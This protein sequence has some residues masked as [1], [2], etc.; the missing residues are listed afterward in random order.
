[1]GFGSILVED[2]AALT[3]TVIE[4]ILKADVRCVLAKGWSDRGRVSDPATGAD[5]SKP[6]VPLPPE[7][8]SVKAVP[9]D[10]L[11]QRIDAAVHHGGAGTTGASLRAGLPTIIKPFF[12]DQFFF[13]GRVEDLGVG[14][15]M[16]KLNTSVLARNLWEATHSER[17]IKKAAVL[18][19]QI[20]KEDGVGE[21]I[22]AIYRDVEYAKTL[23]KRRGKM[24]AVG[25]GHGI[26]T[27]EED[28]EETW[29]FVGEEG[30]GD[31][32]AGL[33]GK[34]IPSAAAPVAAATTTTSVG[35]IVERRQSL[36]AK[37]MGAEGEAKGKGKQKA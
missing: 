21:A 15:H 33:G 5:R 13:A 4:S 20:R 29:T 16:K 12:G 14:I 37:G 31:T 30:E 3:K 7:I 36:R 17:M 25:S 32:V 9:H 28:W 19:E 27:G 1:M 34:W 10:W 11:F 26:G 8:F 24:G 2:S 6:E 18:G 23:V 35:G 22:K